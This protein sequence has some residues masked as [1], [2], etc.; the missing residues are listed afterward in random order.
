V[1]RDRVAS[2]FEISLRKVRGIVRERIAD[3]TIGAFVLE[4]SALAVFRRVEAPEVNHATSHL[5]DKGTRIS[6][7]GVLIEDSRWVS[8]AC[9]EDQKANKTTAR[10]IRKANALELRMGQQIR[11]RN[12]EEAKY[13]SR[14][15]PKKARK[16]P[17]HIF[18]LLL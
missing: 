2:A 10:H 4:A 7:G 15:L 16:K 12:F 5:V 13:I 9:W 3:G 17:V 6:A 8:V 14:P 11:K 1:A 18:L